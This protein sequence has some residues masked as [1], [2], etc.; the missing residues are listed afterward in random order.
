M[1][2]TNLTISILVI[3][4]L[5]IISLVLFGQTKTMLY[6]R[7]EDE[8]KENAWK[9]INEFYPDVAVRL[10]MSSEDFFEQKLDKIYDFT[11]LGNKTHVVFDEYWKYAEVYGLDKGFEAILLEDD[12]TTIE[13]N[14]EDRSL[15]VIKYGCYFSEIHDDISFVYDIDEGKV[16]GTFGIM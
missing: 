10:A 4:G 7:N 3:L 2:R 8:Y 1:R 11:Y 9:Q 13:V 15:I 5:V 16:L 6:S 14:N 12:G